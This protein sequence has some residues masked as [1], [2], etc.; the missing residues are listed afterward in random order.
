MQSESDLD[1]HEADD[2]SRE[3]QE[4][5]TPLRREDT[6]I[7][8]VRAESS[9]ALAQ[10]QTAMNMSILIN[11]EPITHDYADV[12]QNQKQ[13][14]KAQN[15]KR[16]FVDQSNFS[17]FSTVMDEDLAHK[18]LRRIRQTRKHSAEHSK[19]KLM[20]QNGE[21]IEENSDDIDNGTESIAS[22]ELSDMGSPKA[23]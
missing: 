20:L 8:K 16:T 13:N 1:R 7:E 21:V 11:A 4:G 12:E 23:R 3:Q 9:E 5:L 18:K 14:A 19:R 22:A 15:F 17:Y 2:S 10:K 6:E